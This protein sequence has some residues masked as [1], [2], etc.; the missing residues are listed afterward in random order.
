MVGLSVNRGHWMDVGGMAAGGWSGSAR[1][2]VQEG[3]II[4]VAKLY[5]A[6]EVN[7]EVQEFVLKNVRMPRLI[8]GDIQAQV[9]SARAA[10]ERVRD[11]IDKYGLEQV[12]RAIQH[13]IDYAKHR[14]RERMDSLPN[15][16][17]EA[18]DVMDD[19]GFGNG[20]YRIKVIIDKA[21]DLIRVDFA[22]SDR[23]AQ[24]SANCTFALTKAAVCTALKALIDAEMPL[25]SGILD[26]IEITAPPGTI[27][28]PT[29][30]SPVFFG[31]ADPVARVTETV[32]RAWAEAVPERV[33]AGSYSS[34]HNSTGW[35]LGPD[36]SET[37]W[38]VFGPGGCG[39][40]L[41]RD[42]LT[43]EWH[44]IV[45][46]AN[47]SMEIWEARF[48][49]RFVKRELRKDSAGA[50]RT[51]G[52]LGD[53]R[54]IEVTTETY[55]SACADRFAS[56]PWA[57]GEGM[58]GASNQFAIERDGVERPFTEV[59]GI[60]SPSKFSNLLLR[61]GDRVIIRA[62]GGGGFGPPRERPAD[63]VAWDVRNE[64]V[65]P[66]AARALYGVAVSP[67]G[68]VNQAATDELRRQGTS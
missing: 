41:E 24:G 52:G 4:P 30:P 62:G 37:L 44:P 47:E 49:V 2:V 26:L 46:C 22:G 61:P 63:R 9:A 21:P 20:P 28:N 32:L 11:L 19:D 15:G 50:G 67:D 16:H 31:T 53:A 6:G 5:R 38:Y 40:R 10:A 42:G 12:R 68:E 58:P 64:F 8:W 29:Y 7:R 51:R 13:S 43:A 66:E 36:G 55:L 1:H 33:V 14:F 25:N 35:S 65:S 57:V 17:F 27:V 60:S 48:P 45:S 23:Q 39:A 34:G 3:L 56:Q 54:V 18:E 59:F